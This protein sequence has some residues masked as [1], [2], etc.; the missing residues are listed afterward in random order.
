MIIR[1][2]KVSDAKAIHSIIS[3]FAEFDRMLFRSM[4]SIYENIQTFIVAED[5]NKQVVGCAAM[6]VLWSD[7]AE[8]KSLAVKREMSGQGIGKKLV[9]EAVNKAKRLGV[10]RI[11]ALTLEP[12]FFEKAGFIRVDRK[13]LPMKV[14][15]DCANCPKQDQCDE[16]AFILDLQEMEK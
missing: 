12:I 5:D 4:A 2:A 9:N 16:V 7:L 11:F 3:D 14:W 1:N 8:V 15:S 6:A 13:T 10:T